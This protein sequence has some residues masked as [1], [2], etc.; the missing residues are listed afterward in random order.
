MKKINNKAH[1]EIAERIEKLNSNLE[2]VAN[3]KDE[4]EEYMRA[5]VAEFKVDGLT[6]EEFTDKH[7]ELL[8]NTHSLVTEQT[9]K[10]DCYMADRSDN[11]H[12]TENGEATQEW[13]EELQCLESVL[14]SQVDFTCVSVAF[15]CPDLE[16]F[17]VPPQ[18]RDGDV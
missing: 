3:F 14:E 9:G 8:E 1:Q 10:I 17:E 7:N 18:H 12:D 4:L 5:K 15:D 11:W 13:L 2:Q 16:P 6:L